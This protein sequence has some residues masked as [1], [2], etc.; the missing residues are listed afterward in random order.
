MNPNLAEKL[1]IVDPDSEIGKAK[2][3]QR[4]SDSVASDIR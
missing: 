4:L 2:P 1:G 3:L